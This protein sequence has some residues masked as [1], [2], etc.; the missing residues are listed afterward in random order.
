MNI[1]ELL[2]NNN[3]NETTNNE[4]NLSDDEDTDANLESIITDSGSNS[5][6]AADL[7]SS[8]AM[9]TSDSAEASQHGN[10]IEQETTDYNSTFCILFIGLFN[11]SN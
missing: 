7:A 4:T 5:D 2:E 10:N 3:N 11:F 1:C 6:V 8:N 9:N